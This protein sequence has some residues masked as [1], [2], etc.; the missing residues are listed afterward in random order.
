VRALVS[1]F[2]DDG[3]LNLGGSAQVVWGTPSL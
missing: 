2:V 3:V 1:P